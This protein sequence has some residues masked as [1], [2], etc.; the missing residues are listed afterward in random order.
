ML[1]IRVSSSFWRHQRNV[2]MNCVTLWP[3]YECLFIYSCCQI[4]NNIFRVLRL[5]N[6]L[7]RRPL[8]FCSKLRNSFFF[9]GGG[10]EKL[11]FNVCEA[12]HADSWK[13]SSL[14]ELDR[15]KLPCDPSGRSYAHPSR[16]RSQCRW[17]KPSGVLKWIVRRW[18]IYFILFLFLKKC[19]LPS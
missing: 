3:L 11:I 16:Y 8:L 18:I 13:L 5:F 7:R 1:I 4:N 14:S 15:T 2:D 12:V 9:F 10:E 19:R 17:K 6:S